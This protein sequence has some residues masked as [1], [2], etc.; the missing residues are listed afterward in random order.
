[1][2]DEL[3]PSTESSPQDEFRDPEANEPSTSESDTENNHFFKIHSEIITA[4]L[5]FGKDTEEARQWIKSS[6][7]ITQ[8]YLESSLLH[9]YSQWKLKYPLLSDKE[10]KENLISELGTALWFLRGGVQEVHVQNQPK[11]FPNRTGAWKTSTLLKILGQDQDNPGRISALTKELEYISKK[12]REGK[13]SLP[14]PLRNADGWQLIELG[15]RGKGKGH[16]VQPIHLDRI[17][18][19]YEEMRQIDAFFE[20]EDVWIEDD[21][22][23]PEKQAR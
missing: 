21:D 6:L 1:M 19:T 9:E 22:A 16:L 13:R 3:M 18:I 23:S 7:K 17:E 12:V 20:S 5:V 2:K 8:L 4:F 15:E 10:M 14:C 11:R